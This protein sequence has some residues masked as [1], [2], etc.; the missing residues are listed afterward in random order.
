MSK[1]LS[2]T[3]VTALTH[4]EV[5]H[6]CEVMS[7]LCL[8]AMRKTLAMIPEYKI[9]ESWDDDTKLPA[10][11]RAW[12]ATLSRDARISSKVEAKAI[13]HEVHDTL[14]SQWTPYTTAIPYA[15]ELAHLL[16]NSAE[17]IL[18][19]ASLLCWHNLEPTVFSNST[20]EFKYNILDMIITA[21]NFWRGHVTFFVLRNMIHN[22]P[23]VMHTHVR[24]TNMPL[25]IIAG[26]PLRIAPWGFL[27]NESWYHII[28]KYAEEVAE[29]GGV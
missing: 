26:Y 3:T 6:R 28:C 1:I 14:M 25:S 2:G 20:T 22:A 15:H 13:M 23:P 24:A 29:E 21:S 19:T 16:G 7:Q 8:G 11:R 10:T 17:E 9:N 27:S 12:L 4:N 5:A 18:V